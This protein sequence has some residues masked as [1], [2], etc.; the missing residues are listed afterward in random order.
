MAV[1]RSQRGLDL[2]ILGQARP[3]T[4]VAS[5]PKYV[6]VLGS[7]SIG[8]KPT[9][10]VQA[11]DRVRPGEP[12]FEDKKNPGVVYTSPFGGTVEAVHR[13]ERRAFLSLVIAVDESA[14]P[15]SFE[16][17][18]GKAPE[19]LSGDEIR[20]LLLE[21]GEW[22]A[23]RSRPFGR[24]AKPGDSPAAILVNAT[25]SQPLAPNPIGTIAGR[26]D[27]FRAGVQL[28]TGL[29]EGKVYVTTAPGYSLELP[30]N[31]RVRHE[32]F[33]GPHPAGTAGYQIHRLA[34]VSAER[35]VWHLD[36]QEAVALGHLAL[37]GTIDSQRVVAYG[38]PA[39]DDARWLR[40]ARGA[41]I[42]EILQAESNADVRTI[43]G[44]VLSGR[45]VT[46]SETAFLGRFDRQISAID[47]NREREFLGWLKPGGN[48]FS[49]TRA[50]TSALSSGKQFA[51]GS[52]TNGS[53]RAIVPIG[54]HERV[55]PFDFEPTF[56]LKALL[57]QDLEQAEELGCL[58]LVEEDVDLWTFVCPG[59]NDYRSA[60][61]GVLDELERGN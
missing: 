18:N 56:L 38:G 36:A 27:E 12:L 15:V 19:E 22:S 32:I 17:Y 34:P 44:S 61:R 16:A 52:S 13:G 30:E 33:S 28:L 7:E 24:V 3:E 50:F 25:D 20:A 57:M 11:G 5:T 51:F 59:K 43:A 37:T 10:R 40:V 46:D 35:T 45:Q 9:M 21:S 1:H 47:E 41:S 14:E 26:E 23:I 58:E 31:D 48:L 8:L 6:A 53:K 55:N 54:L 2:P 29:T 49:L 42:F 60:L 4:E 39:A